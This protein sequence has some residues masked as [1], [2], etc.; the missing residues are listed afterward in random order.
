[1]FISNGYWQMERRWLF[2]LAGR[3]FWFGIYDPRVSLS[4]VLPIHPASL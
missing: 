2:V 4:T 3:E 1:M